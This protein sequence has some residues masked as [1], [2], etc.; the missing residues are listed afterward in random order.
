MLTF[1]FCNFSSQLLFLLECGWLLLGYST[2]LFTLPRSSSILR[3]YELSGLLVNRFSYCSFSSFR[4]STCL[5]GLSR[6]WIFR[7]P[8][9]LS[10]T[11]SSSESAL[12]LLEN[13]LL[14]KDCVVELMNEL[15]VIKEF[16]DSIRDHR[17]LENLIYVGSTSRVHWE[18]GIE[19][20]FKPK[21]KGTR[22]RAEVASHYLQGQSVKGV[23]VEGRFKGTHLIE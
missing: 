20:I 2:L 10:C 1:P 9:F 4:R 21:R 13:V 6:L 5:G 19:H 12:R 22:Y 18:H 16:L 15:I 11:F 17:H 23:T 3:S 14:V 8:T 7:N